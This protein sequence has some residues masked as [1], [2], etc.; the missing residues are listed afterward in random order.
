MSPQIKKRLMRTLIFCTLA[1]IVGGGVGYLQAQMQS[2][3]TVTKD[4]K[5]SDTVMPMAGLNIGGPYNL[6][7]D[8]GEAVTQ[9]TYTGQYK[10]IY[11]GFTYCPAI[12][13]T[14]LQKTTRVLKVIEEKRPELA[15]KIQPLF[16]TVDPERDTV[17]VMH[18]YVSLFHPRLIGLTGT[19]PQIDMVKKHYRIFATKVQ[20]ESMN[21]YTMDHSS[22]IYLMSPEDELLGMYRTS[23]TPDAMYKDV[24]ARIEMVAE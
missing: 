19:V 10:L 12:C 18:E 21:D 4:G 23:D 13:P 22:F 20:D 6:I 16:I 17:D 2:A 8:D 11:F 14:E 15:E 24:V 5:S 9:D 3:R 1:L 7:N